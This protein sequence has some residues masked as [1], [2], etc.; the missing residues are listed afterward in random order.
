[1][2]RARALE[3]L[4]VTEEEIEAAASKSLGALGLPRAQQK[5]QLEAYMRK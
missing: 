3:R 4:G 1:M 2:K 5:S